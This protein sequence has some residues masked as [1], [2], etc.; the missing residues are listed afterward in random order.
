MNDSD[1][2]MFS[3]ILPVYN[4][5][6]NIQ[7]MVTTLIQMYPGI[8]V[9]VMDDNSKDNTISICRKM[10]ESDDHV[11]IYVRDPSDKGLTASVA[12]GITHVETEYFIVM[13]ADFQHPPE[14]LKTI[15]ESLLSGADMVI[16][17]R[18]EKNALTTM[19]RVYSDCAQLLAAFYLKFHGQPSSNDIMSGLFGSRSEMCSKVVNEKG[20]EFE[21]PGFKVLFDLLKFISPESNVVEIDYLFGDRAGG[22]SKLNTSIIISVLNQCGKIGKKTAKI[23]ALL[24]KN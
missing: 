3:V 17:K 15:M 11:K 10:E 8:R 12:E 6:E 1:F 24:I 20:D 19:R 13:D 5:E 9:L 2:K 4:E 18:M 16:G 7:N 14:I 23:A 22:S 21:R